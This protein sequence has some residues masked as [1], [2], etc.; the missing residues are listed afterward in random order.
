MFNHSA[1]SRIWF[2]RLHSICLT[3]SWCFKFV[4]AENVGNFTVTDSCRTLLKYKETFTYKIWASFI[5]WFFFLI[6]FEMLVT[7]LNQIWNIS[8]KWKSRV[9]FKF[10][11]R[12]RTPALWCS[13]K[14]RISVR[15][16]CRLQFFA[17]HNVICLTHVH[18]VR[19]AKNN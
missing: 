4:C 8:W 9:F 1:L 2:L 6:S 19:T 13:T 14:S 5:F 7:N 15:D 16:L 12:M 18:C 10:L 11:N 3:T 17:Q